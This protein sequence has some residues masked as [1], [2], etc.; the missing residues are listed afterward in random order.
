[1]KNYR[2][3]IDGK[4]YRVAVNSVSDGV[5]DV[6]VNGKSYKVAV[7]A[8]SGRTVCAPLPGRIVS[9]SVAVGD[10][11]KE[12]QVVAILETMKME[13]E[14]LSEYDGRVSEVWVRPG[15]VVAGGA[16]LIVIE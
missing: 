7:G 11:I 13:N 6:T 2:Y 4:Q 14:I 16:E 9:V 1:M 8:A 5:A 15:E 3:T 12:G 10:E